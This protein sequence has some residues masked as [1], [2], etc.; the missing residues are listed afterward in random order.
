MLGTLFSRPLTSLY[1][2]D[3]AAIAAAQTRMM[4]TLLPHAIAA[5]TGI[6]SNTVQAFGYSFLSTANSVV[7]VLLF[8][9][10][11]MNFIYP[12][13]PTFG[14]L[15]QCYLVSWML[16]LLTNIV[17]VLV[18]YKLRLKKGKIKSV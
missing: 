14:M 2:S 6:L 12:K 11:W 18:L 7:S 16:V 17:F 8:R 10:V 9:I 13:N 4:Y 1:V 15:C 5:A 3:E